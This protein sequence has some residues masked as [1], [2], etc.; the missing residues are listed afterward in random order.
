MGR[1]SRTDHSSTYQF[2][3]DGTWILGLMV[4]RK[5]DTG[6]R[7]SIILHYPGKQRYSNSPFTSIPSS[8][9][10]R[11]AILLLAQ[12]H[13]F[14]SLSK[15]ICWSSMPDWRVGISSVRLRYIFS[16]TSRS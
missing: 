6:D 12:N 5:V 15:A 10:L 9:R 7:S 14:A 1:Y 16:A 3:T 8:L 11:T 4:I 13:L 2:Q